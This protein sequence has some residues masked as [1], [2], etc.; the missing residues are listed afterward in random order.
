MGAF[1][2]VLSITYCQSLLSSVRHRAAPRVLPN[3]ISIRGH[4]HLLK[5]TRQSLRLRLA[6]TAHHISL[7]WSLA[8]GRQEKIFGL[9]GSQGKSHR[10]RFSFAKEKHQAPI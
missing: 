6:R 10:P 2:N 7:H 4:F 3:E 8:R 1:A 9:V 5:W